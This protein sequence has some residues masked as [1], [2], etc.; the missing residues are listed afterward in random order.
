MNLLLGIFL[1]YFASRFFDG[2]G[3]YSV[4]G[5]NFRL[6]IDDIVLT[7]KNSIV[8]FHSEK[9]GRLIVNVTLCGKFAIFFLVLVVISSKQNE[10]RR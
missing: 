3:K 1:G 5:R 8:V 7:V 9:V 10:P 2:M 6:L 4:F